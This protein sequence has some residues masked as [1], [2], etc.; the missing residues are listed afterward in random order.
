MEIV[1]RT[2]PKRI[3]CFALTALAAL[4]IATFTSPAGAATIAWGPATTISG[5]S[6]VMTDYDLLYA[7]NIAGTVS[8]TVNGVQFGA[9]PGG[10][11]TGTASSN[12]THFGTASGSPWNTLSSS[13]QNI[14]RSADFTPSGGP[15]TRTYTL[16]N[17]TVGMQYWVQV[18]THGNRSNDANRFTTYDGAVSLNHNVQNANGGVGQF[19]IGTFIAD[20]TTQSFTIQ[21]TNSVQLNAIQVRVP[22][23]GSLALLV[24]GTGLI[25]LRRRRSY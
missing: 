25:L 22:E 16:Q 15:H 2:I 5:D 3:R 8:P 20:A 18:W 23:P 4:A 10:N 14:L 9:G 12:N 13:Y 24:A 1:N 17:L 21:G 11:I 7:Q 19:A 6:D